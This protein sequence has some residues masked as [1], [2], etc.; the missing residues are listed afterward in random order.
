MARIPKCCMAGCNNVGVHPVDVYRRGQ[1]NAFLCD[2]HRNN[3]AS[4]YDEN[5]TVTGVSKKNGVTV[6]VEFETGCTTDKGRI[7][8][9]ASGYMPTH[10]ATVTHEYKSPIMQGLNGLSKHCVTI[11]RLIANGDVELD[12]R[13]GT[14][15]NVGI[16]GKINADSIGKI[17][18]FY[19]SIF[20]PL[21]EYLAEHPEEC[22]AVFGRTLNSWARPISRSTDARAHENFVNLQHDTHIEYRVCK[23]VSAKQYMTAARLC[24]KMTECIVTNFVE[25]FNDLGTGRTA[26]QTAHRKH[27]ASVT[28]KKLVGLF[29]KA[30]ASL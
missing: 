17:A 26:E 11:D 7:E 20:L 25:H 23:F 29:K 4:Y 15:F 8:L 6:S 21:S 22:K 10:D 27:K 1:R 28:A 13:C 16:V 12:T 14:H 24:V 18:R 19:H 5:N 3:D 30:Y 2:Y 9:V